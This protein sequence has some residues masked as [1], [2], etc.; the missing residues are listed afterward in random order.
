MRNKIRMLIA[1]ALLSGSVTIAIVAA[2]SVAP[3][4]DAVP[5]V[6]EAP[7]A[8][9]ALT[10]CTIQVT[11]MSG[12]S[13]TAFRGTCTGWTGSGLRFFKIKA[14]CFP[15]GEWHTYS[16]GWYAAGAGWQTMSR[17]AYW[18]CSTLANRQFVYSY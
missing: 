7:V 6:E 1:A 16:G 5:V 2:E 18:N 12:M 10:G 15:S 4:A 8:D 9:A 3:V 13:V 17:G 14:Q 11:A